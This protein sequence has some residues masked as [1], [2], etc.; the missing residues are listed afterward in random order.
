MEGKNMNVG[1][2]SALFVSSLAGAAFAVEAADEILVQPGQGVISAATKKAH[3]G[4]VIR[5]AEGEFRDAVLVPEGITI[6]GAGPDKTI[7][8]GT[9]ACVINCGGSNI[10]IMDLELRPGKDRLRGVS[11]TM[12][13]RVVRCRFRGFQQ[14]IGLMGAP[15]S[16]VLNCEFIDC[17]IGVRAIGRASPSVLGCRFQAGDVGILCVDGTPYIWNNLFLSQNAGVRIATNGLVI[18]RNNVFWRCTR[19]GVEVPEKPESRGV[20]S[21]RN[22]IFESCGA[23]VLSSK[24]QAKRVS[25]CLFHAIQVPAFR[26][27]QGQNTL[28]LANHHLRE[29]DSRLKLDSNGLVSAEHRE[30][31]IGKGIRFCTE[32]EAA[33]GD[34]GLLPNWDRP[35]VKPREGVPLQGIRFQGP[36]Y[37]ANGVGEE[38]EFV[39]SMGLRSTSQSLSLDDS[40]PIDFLRVKEDGGEKAFRFDIR[41]FFGEESLPP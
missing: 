28:E 3:K 35:G 18:I 1:L 37:L 39:A 10:Q 5:L 21:I 32:K 33:T 4:Q 19:A 36:A 7:I 8:V 26:D 34:I 38:H 29:L 41:R 25:H 9:E 6:Q 13:V 20:P 40:V 14:A 11:G 16:D 31:L 27:E 17:G 24:D 30:S 22:N 2:V 23:A 15:L 12:P